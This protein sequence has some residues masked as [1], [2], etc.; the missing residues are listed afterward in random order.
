MHAHSR[1]QF[2]TLHGSLGRGL[3]SATARFVAFAILVFAA[4]LM[5]GS[6]RPDVQSLVI[7]RPL[8]ILLG[9]YALML[10]TREQLRM[11]AVPALLLLALAFVIGIQL[12]P[13]PPGLWGSLPGRSVI[14]D[15]GSAMGLGD[16]W[17]PLS[18]APERTINA[19]FAL[20]IPGAALLL[21]AVQEPDR[22]RGALVLFLWAAIGSALLGVF[23][24]L[25]PDDGPLYTYRVTNSGTPVGFFANRNHQ[26]VFLACMMLIS[27][28]YIVST[29]KRDPRAP[30]HR[31]F[32]TAAL[33]L[34]FVLVLAAG[35]RAGLAALALMSAAS[36]W[37]LAR[38]N[39]IPRRVAL[40]RRSISRKSIFAGLGALLLGLVVLSMAQGRS[41]AIDRLVD[42]VGGD[43]TDL[44]SELAPVLWRMISDQFPY[45][46]GFGSFEDL[47]RTVE[48]VGL[49]S[50]RYLNQAHNDWAQILIEGGLPALLLLVIVLAWAVRRAFQVFR[51][52]PG[53]S[54]DLA[55]LALVVLTMLGLAS[56]VD[57]PLRTPAMAVFAISLVAAVE[58]WARRRQG[59]ASR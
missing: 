12:V 56:I 44:R 22:R 40:G 54:R 58:S 49:L 8:A 23:Q 27:T 9:G 35:S 57:Y 38:G 46:S 13:L 45:G 1:T 41:L 48:P 24:L 25:G 5:G 18:L 17:R 42:S 52:A 7:L 6:A 51:A 20:T 28:W 2:N 10:I 33:L 31:A 53:P 34:C 43:G 55:L 30:L 47:Y 11:I 59:D 16:A 50:I 21:F 26:G 32:G 39:L 14:A 3:T 4:F 37:Y 19:L 15:I 36:L 29:D